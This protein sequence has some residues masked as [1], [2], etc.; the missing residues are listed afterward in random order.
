MPV[1]AFEPK[2]MKIGVLTAALQE[3]T[4]RENRDP[5]P[6][7]AIEERVAFARELGADYIQLSA[8]LHPTK[9]DIPA[10]AMLDP[11]ANTLD[12]R[13][14]FDRERAKRVKAALEAHSIGLSDLAYFDN[15]LHEDAK[16][17]RKKHDFMRRVMDAAVLLGVDQ[18]LVAHAVGP[19]GDEQ[20][21]RPQADAEEG[22]PAEGGPDDVRQEA[23]E[24]SELA[25]K[26]FLSGLRRIGRGS[27]AGRFPNTPRQRRDQ[28]ERLRPSAPA[29]ATSQPAAGPMRMKAASGRRRA[30]MRN[31]QPYFAC[32]A[33]RIRSASSPVT[34]L[35]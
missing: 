21:E 8:A 34:S 6:D 7:L 16:V 15:M 35:A 20:D 26:G 5:D 32:R 30:I 27:G 23:E 22:V 9:S 14:P 17:R 25:H 28:G 10:E 11:V 19:E 24:E 13:K 2:F 31:I 12:L 3:L 4:P 1:A 33:A 18:H 29:R